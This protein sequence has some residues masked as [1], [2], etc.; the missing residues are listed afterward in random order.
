MK[1][2]YITVFVISMENIWVTKKLKLQIFSSTLFFIFVTKRVYYKQCTNSPAI[3]PMK[4]TVKKKENK[5]SAARPW[6]PGWQLDFWSWRSQACSACC[7]WPAR[8]WGHWWRRELYLTSSEWKG[9]S[10]VIF[11]KLRIRIIPKLSPPP[12]PPPP[13]GREC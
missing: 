9:S 8:T 1:M 13:C 5:H 4:F 3:D 2:F 12:P 10:V 6:D 7:N 11:L